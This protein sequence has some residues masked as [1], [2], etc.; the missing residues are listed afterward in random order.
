MISAFQTAARMVRCRRP[1]IAAPP[2]QPKRHAMHPRRRHRSNSLLQPLQQRRAPIDRVAARRDATPPSFHDRPERPAP[3]D[4]HSQRLLPV[5]HCCSLATRIPAGSPTRARAATQADRARCVATADSAQAVHCDITHPLNIKITSSAGCSSAAHSSRSAK[6]QTPGPC[7][8][9]GDASNGAGSVS[10]F[11]AAP[12]RIG[13]GGAVICCQSASFARCASASALS[14]CCCCSDFAADLLS[15]FG[16]PVTCAAALAGAL[17]SVAP[18]GGA[19]VTVAGVGVAG[20]A[21]FLSEAGAADAASAGAGE[22]F[23]SAEP[24]GAFAAAAP[25]WL[26]LLPLPLLSGL[27][28]AFGTGAGACGCSG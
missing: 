15:A 18:T 24:D 26:A 22:A 27:G 4:S 19:A 20:A 9:S 11:S 6:G 8:G 10:G 23:E 17:L 14:C 5:P 3:T 16:L 12:R 28:A 2:S 1:A 7:R 25:S 21:S 13:G